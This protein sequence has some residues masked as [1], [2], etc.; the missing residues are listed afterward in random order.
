[1]MS[2]FGALLDSL[3]QD[4][5][6]RSLGVFAPELVLCATILVT[7][8]VRLFDADRRLPTYWVALVGAFGA[9]LL[10]YFQFVQLRQGGDAEAYFTGLLVFDQF[11]VFFRVFLS[12]FLVLV[13]SLTILTG[14]PDL[15][16]GPDFY[17]LLVGST[18]GMMLMASANHLLILFLG[19]EMASVPSYAMVGFLK[20][21][22][23]SSEAALKYVVYG[24]G[25]AGVMLYGVSLLAGLLGTANLPQI[26][27]Q[28]ESLAHSGRGIVDPVVRTAFLGALMILAG[29]AFK[30]S[31]VPFHF[32]CPDAFEGAPAEV[33]GYLSVASKAAAFALLVRFCLAFAG[34]DA[35]SLQALFRALGVG[36]GLVA[37]VTATYGNLVA[38][39]QNNMKRL[40]AYSTIAHAG[41][42]LM[43]VA[44]VL[45]ISNAPAGAPFDAAVESRRCLEGLLYYL[46]V[47]LF[48]NLGAFA[49][50]ALIRNEIFSEDIRDYNGLGWQAPLLGVCMAICLF[51]LTGVPPLGGFVGKLFIFASV[52]QAAKI[53]PW[54][55]VVLVLG[56]LNTVFSL[57]YY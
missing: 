43:A 28:L 55:W 21:R 10:S 20:G 52:I 44:A 5:I 25:A 56:L 26:A 34:S 16:D 46:C 42:M 29:L 12:L 1:M 36:L 14:L 51:S 6:G 4:T 15:E 13:V 30:L 49:I 2:D 35:E 7:L 54:M 37:V 31:L 3:L 38:F 9:F 22:R 23:S 8:F 48:M 47:Y 50:V 11:S 40:L 27:A 24:A 39:V 17:T 18:I 19:V 32:W 41:Y 53:A 45:I 33:A 57:F